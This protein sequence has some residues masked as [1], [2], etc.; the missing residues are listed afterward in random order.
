MRLLGAAVY[1][2]GIKFRNCISTDPQVYHNQAL[3]FGGAIIKF[4]KILTKVVE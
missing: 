3:R 1:W 2:L 4:A